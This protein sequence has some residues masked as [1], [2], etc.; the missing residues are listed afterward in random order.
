VSD[1][2][3]VLNHPRFFRIERCHMGHMGECPEGHVSEWDGLP[4][5]RFDV[6]VGIVEG[7]VEWWHAATWAEAVRLAADAIRESQIGGSR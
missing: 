7:R 5:W 2:E 4:C 3:I 1:A 6:G